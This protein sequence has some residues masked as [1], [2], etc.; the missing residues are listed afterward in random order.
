LFND[1]DEPVTI[2]RRH[3]G[4]AEPYADIVVNP[5]D[6]FE[7]SETTYEFLVREADK[8]LV[9][10][11]RAEPTSN[12]VLRYADRKRAEMLEQERLAEEA[13]LAEESRL[14]Q[15]Q[16]AALAAQN[17]PPSNEEVAQLPAGN[18]VDPAS[19]PAQPD[20]LISAQLDESTPSGDVEPTGEG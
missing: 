17:A 5:G 9:I 19:I 10:A 13:R 3:K 20:T 12:R 18:E 14:Q 7:A 2:T 1:T 16:A 8:P 11:D 4:N 15:E 6:P